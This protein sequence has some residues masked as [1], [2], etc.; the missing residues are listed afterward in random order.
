MPQGMHTPME[1]SPRRALRGSSWIDFWVNARVELI[2]RA[3][4]DCP[5]SGYE[6]LIEKLELPVP[7]DRP[8]LAA[9]MRAGAQAIVAVNLKDC[10][11]ST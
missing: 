6:H 8:I 10:L 3:V 4:P 5:V 1:A 11:Q 9:A 2:H 7:K